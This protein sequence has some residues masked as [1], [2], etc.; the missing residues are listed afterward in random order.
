M[1]ISFYWHRA[2][3]IYAKHRARKSRTWCLSGHRWLKTPVAE[4]PECV[5]CSILILFCHTQFPW[6]QP[7]RGTDILLS[8]TATCVP[9]NHHAERV[10]FAGNKILNVHKQS[11]ANTMCKKICLRIHFIISN[12]FT[13]S[14]RKN[15]FVFVSYNQ[16]MI[17]PTNT[18][19]VQTPPYQLCILYT[20][21]SRWLCEKKRGGKYNP[22]T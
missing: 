21:N 3:E 22:K 18:Y 10:K 5:E 12:L 1:L 15:D 20:H 14:A 8:K 13:D 2:T 4:G 7:V 11:D 19:I 16:E 6:I 9:R 17:C